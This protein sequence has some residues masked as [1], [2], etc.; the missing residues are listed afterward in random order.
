[1]YIG[2]KRILP[3]FSWKNRKVGPASEKHTIKNY[4]VGIKGVKKR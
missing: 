4:E 1:M 2:G 3:A